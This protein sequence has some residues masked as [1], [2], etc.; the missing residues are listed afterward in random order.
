MI[1]LVLAAELF[2]TA[3]EQLCDHLHPEKHANIK[4]VKDVAAGAVLILSIGALWVA[5]LMILSVMV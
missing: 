4:V 2:N 1:V 5:L 3:L